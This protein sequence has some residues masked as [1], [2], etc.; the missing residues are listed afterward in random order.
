M[1]GLRLGPGDW[2]WTSPITFVASANCGRYCGADVDFVDID[3]ETGL[4]SLVAL[5]AKLERAEQEGTLPKLVVPVHLCGTSCDMASI[6]AL[7]DRYGFAV[8][9]GA[10]H[11][12]G[13]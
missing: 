13:G 12:I 11:A 1:L 6:A 7:A 9:E 3:P 2:L 4:I 5:A 10:S 8:L